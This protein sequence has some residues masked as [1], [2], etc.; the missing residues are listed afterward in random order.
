MGR[1]APFIAAGGGWKMVARNCGQ[2]GAVVQTVW[3]TGGPM[4]FY[5]FLNYPNWLKYKN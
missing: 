1:G 3:L 4:W 2:R 5:I